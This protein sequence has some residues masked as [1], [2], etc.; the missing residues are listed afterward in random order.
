[1]AGAARKREPTLVKQAEEAPNPFTPALAAAP[2]IMSI[3]TGR[4]S[5]AGSAICKSRFPCPGTEV[6]WV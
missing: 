2:R 3:P 6:P 5:P 4:G 1:M